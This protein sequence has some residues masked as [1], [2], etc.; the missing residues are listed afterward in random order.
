MIPVPPAPPRPTEIHRFWWILSQRKNSVCLT[1]FTSFTMQTTNNSRTLAETFWNP[2][3]WIPGRFNLIVYRLTSTLFQNPRLIL[4]VRAKSW[5]LDLGSRPFQL[6]L[7]RFNRFS[8][9][10]KHCSCTQAGFYFRS[11]AFQWDLSVS[12]YP[13]IAILSPCHR[14]SAAASLSAYASNDVWLDTYVFPWR[15]TLKVLAPK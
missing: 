4:R 8:M 14:L 1:S 2:D 3:S 11:Q 6:K 10:A 12:P 5:I 15:L 9:K 7:F 13:S